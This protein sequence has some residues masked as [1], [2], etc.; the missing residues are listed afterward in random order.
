[1]DKI[2]K[3]GTAFFIF[4]LVLVV[5][6][7]GGYYLIK[8]KVNFSEN[9]KTYTNNNEKTK[10]NKIDSNKDYIYF[11]N[12]E[13]ISEE[14][15]LIYKDIVFNFESEDAKK[16]QSD[17]NDLM[18]KKRNSL[19]KDNEDI[20]EMESIDYE[21]IESSKY[22][23]LMVN[24][25]TYT[26]EEEKDSDDLKYYVFDLYNGKLL[27]NEDIMKKTNISENDIK[28][29]IKKYISEDDNVNIDKTLNNDYSLSIGKNGK[30]KI[31]FVVNSS[32][33]N[34]NVSIEMD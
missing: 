10:I 32:E 19:K 30:V 1:M 31:N 7:G 4:I 22:I 9:N 28:S 20:I 23:S 2:D 11:V 3:N 8:N 5:I 24:E 21:V 14:D 34:Y 12:E 29:K 16:L 33:L 27:S 15:E 17:L 6:I 13:V 18:K 25:Y 26:S